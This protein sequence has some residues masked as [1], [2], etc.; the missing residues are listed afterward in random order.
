[1]FVRIALFPYLSSRLTVLIDVTGSQDSTK[2]ILH[3][4]DIFGIM[5]QT[6]QGADRLATALGILVIMPDWFQGE[7]MKSEWMPPDT[8]EKQA[9]VDKFRTERSGNP[10]NFKILI[11]TAEEAK[12]VWSG[13]NSWGAFGLCWGGKVCI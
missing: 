1:M 6:L 5:P 12:K 2:A 4:Y 13:V 3:V 10:H 11:E 7:P 9:L 8:E